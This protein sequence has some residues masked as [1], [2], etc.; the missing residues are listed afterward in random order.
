MARK[1]TNEQTDTITAGFVYYINWKSRTFTPEYK[2][3]IQSGCKATLAKEVRCYL[4]ETMKYRKK[5][6]TPPWEESVVIDTEADLESI[7][8]SSSIAVEDK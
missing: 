4:K 3:L 8:D 2:A 1:L 7:S 6:I 5:K